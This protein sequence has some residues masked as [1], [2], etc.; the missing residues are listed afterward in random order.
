[1][2]ITAARSDEPDGA[3]R[4]ASLDVLRGVAILGIL[5]MNINDMGQSMLASGADIRHLGW[6]PADRVAWTIRE[7]FF[8]GTARCL[9]E[10]LFGA[11]MVI[12]TERAATSAGRW[13]TMR[14]YYARNV[15]LFGFG[16]VHVFILLWPGEILHTYALAALIA[17]LF[18]RLRPRWL[19]AIGLI[20]AVSQLGGAGYFGYYRGLQQHT[21][22]QRVE[23]RQ[24]AHL[25]LNKGDRALLDRA[26]KA[27]ARRARLASDITAED[28]GRTGSFSDWAHTQIDGFIDLE[29]KGLELLWVWEAASVMLIGAALF[30]LGILQ[31][32]RSRRFYALL[33]IAGYGIGLPLRAIGAAEQMR[34][35][36]LPHTMWATSEIAREATTLGH[37]A[38]I[39]LL[40]ASVAGARLMKPFA[41]A[42]RTALSIYVA[43]TLIT[44][45]LVFPPFALALYGRL[46]WAP[47]MLAALA[48]DAVLLVLANHY[49]R[50]FAIGP[51]E[52]AWRSIVERRRL[53]FRHRRIGASNDGLALPA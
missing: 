37:V 8:N 36:H 6:A 24:Q 45:W 10:M 44:L 31:G 48:I 14:R 27:D 30:K 28:R 16:L 13:A 11:G 32:L 39:S 41:A 42:G 49:V 52:W 34:F 25:P 47:L 7:V 51:V 2:S 23:A 46:T 43:Q 9:L 3:P 17:F 50:S 15:V 5:F 20:A 22:I 35:D 26:A 53:P 12:L 33:A 4:I 21:A 29:S 1:M 19:I 18:R 40:L 38:V